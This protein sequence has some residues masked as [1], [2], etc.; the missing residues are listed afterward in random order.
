M[1]KNL[2][3]ARNISLVLPPLSEYTS[4]KEWEYECWKLITKNEP[5]LLLFI[6]PYE[7]RNIIIRIAVFQR[8]CSGVSYKEIGKELWVS[9]QTIS[10]IVKLMN[11]EEY[12][13]YFKWNKNKPKKN[14]NTSFFV[15]REQS[16]KRRV[17]TKFGTT[18]VSF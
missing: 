18:Y 10:G 15:S 16:R 7:R 2:S 14:N 9:P 13:S 1:K 4:R 5:S 6:T 3:K 11:E 17:R 8:V 12:Q